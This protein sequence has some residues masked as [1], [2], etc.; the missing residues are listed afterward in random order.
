MA[1]AVDATGIRFLAPDA[2]IISSN[3]SSAVV[4]EMRAKV[5]KAKDLDDVAN[6]YRAWFSVNWAPR[7][8]GQLITADDHNALRSAIVNGMSD[9]WTAVLPKAVTAGSLIQ[10]GLWGK[11]K[12]TFPG[13]TYEFSSPG[14]YTVWAPPGAATLHVLQISAGGG[15]GNNG[16]EG[17]DGWSGGSGGSG[18]YRSNLYFSVT[19]GTWLT[20]V[21]GAGGNGCRTWNRQY[22]AGW[23]SGHW[24]DSNGNTVSHLEARLHNFVGYRYVNNFLPAVAG[25]DSYIVSSGQTL[26][27]CTGGGAGSDNGPNAGNPGYAGSPNGNPGNQGHS[28]SDGHSDGNGVDGASSP[29]GTGGRANGNGWPWPSD[30][31]GYGAGGASG[32][33][34]DRTWPWV[35]PGSDGSGGYCKFE[36]LPAT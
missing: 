18:G 25:G 2:S 4:A 24:V 35:W 26:A 14:T 21:I 29:L 10:G 11:P 12:S 13:A 36:L 15:G 33:W 20:V 22:S 34:C 3:D 30:A 6:Y 23:L 7:P 32:G 31:T 1:T 5:I 28:A 16:N 19:G 8:A 27:Y 17:G 9:A